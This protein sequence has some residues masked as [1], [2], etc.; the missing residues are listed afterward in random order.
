M[1]LLGPILFGAMFA[2]PIWLGLNAEDEVKNIEIVDESG[3]LTTA[4]EDRGNL[5]FTLAGKDLSSRKEQMGESGVFGI[6]YIPPTTLDEPKGITFF[7]EK[8]AGMSTI[9]RIEGLLEE[10]FE[11]LKLERS[12]LDKSVIEGLRSKVSLNEIKLANGEETSAS[13]GLYTGIGYIS[14]FLIY[15]F[16]FMYGV[17]IMKGV[18]EE[19]TSRIVEVIISSVKPTQL[20]VGK[21]VGVAAVGFTQFLI[22]IILSFGL[23][24]IGLSTVG[25]NQERIAQIQ[26]MTDEEQEQTEEFTDTQIAISNITKSTESL[27]IPLLVGCFVFYFLGGY[28]LYGSLFAAVGAGADSETDTQQFMLPVTIPLI[29]SIVMLGPVLANPNSTLAFWLSIIPLFSPVIMMMRIPFG[30]PGWE[31]ALSMI[32]LIIGF[33]AIAWLAGRIYRIGIL[34]HGSKVNWKTLGKWVTMKV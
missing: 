10:R 25:L 22:W 27:S 13:T 6:L 19:K 31:I 7:S 23:Y 9:G 17:Q 33:F 32:L 3:L 29:F 20:M 16:I 26:Q 28:L 5:Q 15:I 4:L 30:V 2:V 11:N 34:M 18:V 21:I 14:S 12:E 24:S 8:S 1:S